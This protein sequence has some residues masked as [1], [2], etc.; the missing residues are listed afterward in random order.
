MKSINL[1]K[2]YIIITGV[3]LLSLQ[4]FGQA[5]DL[6]KARTYFE[7]V[8]LLTKKDSGKLWG[9]NLFGPL[10]FVDEKTREG[11]SNT[12]VPI[13]GWKEVNGIYTGKMPDKL[14]F[15]NTAFNWKGES[16]SMVLFSSLSDNKY[17]RGSLM[18]H[19]LFHQHQDKLGL[20]SSKGLSDH[21]NKKMGRALLFL[22]WNALLK[23]S[24]ADGK[25]RLKAVKDALV[26]RKTRA[27]LFPKSF[28]N[29][30]NKELHEGLA[31]YTG[32]SLSGW[33][34]V[35]KLKFLE[36]KVNTNNNDNNTITWTHAYTSGPLYGFL[37][38][39][40]A[41]GWNKKL[42]RGTDLGE[43]AASVFNINYSAAKE[44]Q[45]STIGK[46]YDF[47]TIMRIEEARV[48][49]A[50]ALQESYAKRF[51]NEPTLFLPNLKL[52]IQFNPNKITPY[53][54][55]G[56][57]YGELTGRSAWGKIK[58]KHHGILLLKGWKGLVLDVGK[59]WNPEKS[60]INDRYEI[61]LADGYEI[62]KTEDGW[63]VKREVD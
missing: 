5:I 17:E 61:V 21:L 8:K 7:E 35:D 38:D 42:K 19:E 33:N 59:D 54:N 24:E 14:G 57:V 15:S 3:S 32:M 47:D 34:D 28:P 41:S 2:T 46:P 30:V 44:T 49:A 62:V 31:E 11:V 22:E 52:N 36:R 58:V 55:V 40:Q 27:E 37:L 13:E 20:I 60:L 51:S 1:K 50:K 43:V 29:E 48:A 18:M 23:A 25:A 26:F 53:E 45:L 4:S 16:W 10:V 39:Q 6:E 56:N 12:P 9:I 63:T